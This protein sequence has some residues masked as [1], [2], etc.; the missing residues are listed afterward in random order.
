MIIVLGLPGVGKT[1]V[2]SRV[3]EQNPDWKLVNWGDV[4]FE[5]AKTHYGVGDRDEI[6]HLSEDKQKDIQEKAALKI[7]SMGEKTIVDTHC[8][9]FTPVGYLPGLPYRLLKHLP[10]RLLILLS[11]KPTEIYTRRVK[12]TTRTRELDIEQ[13]EEQLRLNEMYLAAYSALSGANAAIVYNHDNE[14]DKAVDQINDY[15]KKL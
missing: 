12:D 2:L 5:M 15:V 8:S 6:R 9:I 7:A 1:T 14:L 4:M 11:A 3:A 13:I 10:V